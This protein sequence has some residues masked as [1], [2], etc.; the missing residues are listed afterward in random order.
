MWKNSYYLEYGNWIINFL[1][2]NEKPLFNLKITECV[3]L[4]SVEELLKEKNI[5]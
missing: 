3:E 2:P 1:C 4:S 5:L